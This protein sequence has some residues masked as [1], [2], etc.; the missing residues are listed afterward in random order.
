[1]KRRMTK[2]K[3][4][5]KENMGEK[6]RSDDEHR[7]EVKK[8][9]RNKDRALLTPRQSGI[10]QTILYARYQAESVTVKVAIQGSPVAYHFVAKV[11][12]PIGIENFSN[13]SQQCISFLG[14]LSQNNKARETSNLLL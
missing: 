11:D 6:E 5:K 2:K 10:A 14:L 8:R 7:Q 3:K 4:R 13:A 9:K 1:M 12:R